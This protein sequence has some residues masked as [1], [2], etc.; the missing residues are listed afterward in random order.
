MYTP[1]LT[2]EAVITNYL[3]HGAFARRHAA[4]QQQAHGLPPLLC[5]TR[6]W[7]RVQ[8]FEEVV[9]RPRPGTEIYSIGVDYYAW[10]ML[11]MVETYVDK[12]W[13]NALGAHANFCKYT[14]AVCPACRLSASGQQPHAHDANS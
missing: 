3:P 2:P 6:R 14:S 7:I 12:D 11:I 13:K 10:L 1:Y 8:L 4:T 5:W 9:Q